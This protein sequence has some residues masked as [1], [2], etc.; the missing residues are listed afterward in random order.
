M[1]WLLLPPEG[2]DR[3]AGARKRHRGLCFCGGGEAWKGGVSQ[4]QESGSKA[5]REPEATR[6]EGHY[7]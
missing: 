1:A 3:G 5:S 7:S 6:S 4:A 2:E